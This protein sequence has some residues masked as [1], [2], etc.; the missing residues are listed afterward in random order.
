[1]K[2]ADVFAHYDKDN[3]VDDYVKYYLS[4][5][6]EIASEIV[7]VSCNRLADKSNLG[8]SYVIDEPHD[9]YDFGSY[10]RGYLYL[11]DRLNEFDELIFV[12]DSCFGP[13]QPLLPIFEQMEKQDCDFWGITKNNFGYK[14][15][16]AIFM[17]K[18]PHIQSYFIV[19]KKNVFLSNNFNQFIESITHE[20]DKKQ[21]I[22]KYEI[23]LTE[24]LIDCGYRYKTFIDVYKNINNITI[25]KWRQIILKYKMPFMKCSLVKLKNRNVTTVDGYQEVIQQVSNYPVK[26]IENYARRYGIEPKKHTKLS[27]TVKR[28]IF[29]IAACFPYFFRRFLALTVGFCFRFLKDK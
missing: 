23:G 18:R 10:K 24:L 14:K 13:L 5:L 9:E 29:D 22:S 1:M 8:V 15:T 4:A 28:I 27:I 2:R 7:F 19:F 11:K 12:N 17:H 25:L 6:K 20:D 21:I 3:T 16:K 26:L